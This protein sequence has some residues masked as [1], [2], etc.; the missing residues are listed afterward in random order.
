MLKST[1]HIRVSATQI[2]ID[3][4][5]ATRDPR[6]VLRQRTRGDYVEFLPA[7]ENRGGEDLFSS[8]DGWGRGVDSA[9]TGHSAMVGPFPAA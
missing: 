5:V 2:G 8:H 6:P 1:H 9:V 3:T 7:R 4:A